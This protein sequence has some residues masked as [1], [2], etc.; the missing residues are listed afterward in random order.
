MKSEQHSFSHLVKLAMQ[1]GN[2]AQMRAVIEKELLHYDILFALEKGGLLQELVFQGGTSLRLCYGGNRFSEDLDFAG[3][4]SFNAGKLMEM[5]AVIERYIG[6][7]YGLTVSVKEP[8][9]LKQDRNYSEL[10]I[11]KWQIAVITAPE[12]RDVPMQRIKIEVA[13]IP[14]YTK[15]PRALRLNYDFLPD[16]YSDMLILTETLNEVLADKIISLPATQKYVR[17]RDIWDLVWLTQKG[18]T[19]DIKLVENKIKDYKISDYGDRVDTLLLRLP[20]I[21]SSRAF[22]AEM[23]RFIPMD[24]VSRTLADEKFTS[25]LLTTLRSL[26]ENVKRELTGAKINPPFRM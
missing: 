3:G 2:L 15:E 26:F 14:A 24:V 1:D 11:D 5:K 20:D 23:Q 10:K 8:K 18:A 25:Y 19:L 7:R 4:R 13:N 21:T 16:G 6:D 22:F 12:R 9:D 17:Y